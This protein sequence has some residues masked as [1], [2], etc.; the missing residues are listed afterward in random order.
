MVIVGI[1]KIPKAMAD[2]GV[3]E[4]RITIILLADNKEIQ[5]DTVRNKRGL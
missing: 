1:T 4:T 3:K 5:M 2:K